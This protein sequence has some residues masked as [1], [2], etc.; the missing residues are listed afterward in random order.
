M[1]TGA[2]AGIGRCAA[3]LLAHDGYAVVLSDVHVPLATRQS[4]E[5]AGGTAVDAV[6]D[7][8]DA[9]A[10]SALVEA[11][12][13]RFG[14]ID[15]LVNNAGISLIRR[16][17]DTSVHDLRRVLELNFVA[18]FVLAQAFGRMMLE[19]RSGSIVNVASIAGLF[20]V[21]DRA[22]Y[23]ASKHALMGLTRSLAAEWG[24]FGVRTNA[25]CPG[26]VK[27]GMDAADQTSGGYVDAD[28]VDRVPM[29]RFASPGDIAQA[30]LF[31]SDAARSGFINGQA[32]VV[33]GGWTADAGWDSLRVKHRP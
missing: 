12:E 31:L 9:I 29:G 5:R 19:Q 8:T 2:A 30:I 18:P 3:E 17:E 28:I 23:N 6:G 4:I 11:V 15:V 26:W 24:G 1:V 27:T 7:L 10:C 14:R 22:A 21:A 25:V 20:A 33:D 16:A 13:S 32:I